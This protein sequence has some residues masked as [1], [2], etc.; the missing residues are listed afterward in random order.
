MKNRILLLTTYSFI[1]LGIT[2]MAQIPN[3][4]FESLPTI[5]F[6]NT[7]FQKTE[8]DLIEITSNEFY[9]NVSKEKPFLYT[10]NSIQPNEEGYFT[11]SCGNKKYTLQET[12][13]YEGSYSYVGTSPDLRAHYISHCGG[14]TCTDYLIDT[15]NS[16]KMIVP[17]DY[18]QG[19]LGALVS[20][21]GEYFLAYS[22]YDG[23]DFHYAHSI[24]STFSV[25]RI[26][27]NH[28][29]SGVAPFALFESTD[30]SIREMVWMD[31]Q[32]VGIQVYSGN[33]NESA[34]KEDYSYYRIQLIT[35]GEK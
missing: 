29:L 35:A 9:K 16:T 13:E 20:P 22:S 8:F 19:V 10:N 1:C 5:W 23:P 32:S 18:D 3:E 24:R 21:G 28:G 30:W 15:I 14:G 11:I 6:E 25:F 12:G 2:G 26:S 34:T 31:A 17:S 33:L 4:D 27:K 7:A